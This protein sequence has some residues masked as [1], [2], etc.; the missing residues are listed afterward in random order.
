AR[1]DSE[2]TTRDDA[3]SRDGD[4]PSDGAADRASQR[5]HHPTTQWQGVAAAERERLATTE[6]QRYD[7]VCH[8]SDTSALA[9]RDALAARNTDSDPRTL[10]RARSD[11]QRRYPSRERDSASGRGIPTLVR[12]SPRHVLPRHRHRSRYGEH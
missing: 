5:K 1:A 7:R 11:A 10:T 6:R 3:P 9:D 2:S 8:R 12:W 4:A